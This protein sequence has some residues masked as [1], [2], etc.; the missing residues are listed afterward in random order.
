MARTPRRD[1][2][3]VESERG[4]QVWTAEQARR[5]LDLV[6]DHPWRSLWHLALGTGARRGELLGLGWDDVDLPARRLTIRRSLT[7]VDGVARLLGT[8]TSR[9]RTL[10]LGASVVDALWRAAPV[11]AGEHRAGGGW[12]LV[13]TDVDGRHLDP[14]A[15]T[16]EFRR[17]VRELDVP[18][19]RLHDLRHTHASLLL[20]QGVP[21]KVVSDRLGH[22]TI[23]MTMDVY[24]HL[25]PSMDRDAADRLDAAITPP[26]G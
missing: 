15:V 17:L 4:L 21:A 1:P 6:D 2:Y 12:G 19:I 18:V 16:R 13:M 9:V 20:E 7:V 25:M 24:A 3:A 11:A 22:T 14:M 5:F 26:D 23:A 10:S 8:K